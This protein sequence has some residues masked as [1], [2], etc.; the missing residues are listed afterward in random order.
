[1]SKY[2]KMMKKIAVANDG[3]EFL[4]KEECEIKE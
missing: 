4:S 2:T 1:M 3:K